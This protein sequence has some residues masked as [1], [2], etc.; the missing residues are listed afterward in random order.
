M[1]TAKELKYTVD[2][3][4]TATDWVTVTFYIHTGATAKNYRLEVW[5]GDRTATA[6]DTKA[7]SYVFV[8]TNNPGTADSNFDALITEYKELVDENAYFEDVFSYYDTNKFL[9]FNSALDENGYGNLYANGYVPSSYYESNGIAYLEYTEGNDVTFF[10][11]YSLADVTVTADSIP[12]DSDEE[13][14]E[15]EEEDTTNVWLLASSIAVAA[16]LVLAVASIIVRKVVESARKKRGAKVRVE[17]VSK[18]RKEKKVKATK[19]DENSSEDSPY[20]D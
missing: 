16:V 19:A 15:E 1:E 20:N 10:A 13:T 5:S 7:N 3:S 18:P 11:N 6:A 8:D 4:Q 2:G 14:S 12:T 9:R 17:S